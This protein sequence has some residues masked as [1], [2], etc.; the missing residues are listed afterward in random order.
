MADSGYAQ[1]SSGAATLSSGDDHATL[2]KQY[3]AYLDGKSEEIKE[4]QESRRYYHGSQWTEKQ[5]EAFNKRRQ[6]VVT[7]N[8]IGR[9][10]NAIVG[11]LEKQKRDPRG[12]PRTPKHEQGA[13]VATATVRYV[14]DSAKWEELSPLAG[15]DGAVDGIGGCEIVLEQGDVGD[16]DV[17]LESVDPS[18]FFYDPRSLREDFSDA[19]YMGVAKWADPDALKEMFPDKAEIIDASLESGS[20]LTTNPDS[21]QKWIMTGDSGK[22]IRVVDHW[23]LKGRVWHWVIYTGSDILASGMSYLKDDKGRSLCKYIMFSANVD[24]D[25]DR[26]GFIRNMK[27]SQDEVNQRRSKGL[28]VLNTRRMIVRVGEQNQNGGLEKMRLEAAKPD[29]IILY[30]AEKPEFDDSAKAAELNGQLAF[31][32]DAKDEIENFGFNPALIGSGVQD[33][34]GRAIAM[35]QQAGVAELGPYMLA[36][37]GWKLRVYRAIWFAIKEHWTAERWVRVTDDE[38]VPQFLGINQVGI[39]PQ[40]GMPAVVNQLGALDVDIIL[41]EGPDTVNM[42]ADAYETLAVMARGGQQ[43]PP[44]VLIELSPL[45]GSIKKRVLDILKQA[46]QPNPI[47]QAGVQLDMQGKQADVEKTKAETMKIMSDAQ[48]NGADPRMSMMQDQAKLAATIAKA[49]ADQR[50]AALKNEGQQLDNMGK[51]VD[52]M[53][54]QPET[55]G[56]GA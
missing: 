6:P 22:K 2:K 19:R 4:Q 11:L 56:N 20:E 14:L 17:T 10:I 36:F 1:G 25:G 49:S 37:R 13:E 12:F 29:G 53:A 48:K 47:Q 33:M 43:M 16:V 44:E 50:L 5:I 52:L 28:H 21:D 55:Y 18:S 31:L 42:Q 32:Q 51:M 8:R 23:Q 38:N 34:S 3:L 45:A 9:K 15:M 41:D 39:D 26:Y 30:D 27:S 54:P 7:Y 24:H 35:Q 40:T 46:G